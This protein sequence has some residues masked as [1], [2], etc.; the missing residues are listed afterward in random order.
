[1]QDIHEPLESGLCLHDGRLELLEIMKQQIPNTAS[2]FLSVCQTSEADLKVLEEVVH[3]TAGMLAAGYR[4]S[5]MHGPEF[6][7]EFYPYLLKGE[8]VGEV[9]WY[10]GGLCL[11]FRYEEDSR[12]S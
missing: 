5:D 4:I 2:A 1:M 7:M 6:A 8:R 3:L 11:G 9:G 12:E 10:L